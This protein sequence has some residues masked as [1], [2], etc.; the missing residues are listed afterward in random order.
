MADDPL[1]SKFTEDVKNASKDLGKY[2]SELLGVADAVKEAAAAAKTNSGELRDQLNTTTKVRDILD[3]TVALYGRLGSSYISAESLS[4]KILATEAEKSSVLG[5]IDAI[6][7]QIGK[8][9]AFQ[10]LTNEEILAATK[11]INDFNSDGLDINQRALLL[12]MDN[13]DYLDKAI[14]SQNKLNGLLDEGNDQYA[15]T[16]LKGSAIKKV[17]SSIAN[18]PI[19]GPFLQFDLIGEKFQ[20]SIK[21]GYNEIF[22]QS[23]ILFDSPLIKLL[24]SGVIISKLIDISKKYIDLIFEIDK[25]VTKI[26]N[27]LGMSKEAGEALYATFASTSADTIFGSRGLVDGLDKAFYSIRNMS[28]ASAELGESLGTNAMFTDKMVQG[29][30]LMTKQM[31]MTSEEAAGIQSLSLLT[32]KAA[33]KTLQ[34]IIKQNN[35]SLSYRKIIR[36]VANISAELSMRYG[37]DPEQI[38]KAVVQAN[39]LGMSLE[40]T[41]KISNSLLNFEQS[42]EGELESEL[43]L[44]RQ[45]NFEKAR[46]LALMGKSAEASSLLLKQI[47]GITE[48]EKMNVIQRERVAAA[49]GLSVD[50]LSKAAI[51]EQVLTNLGAENEAALTE[52]VRILRENNDLAGMAALQQE[53][54]RVK[55][56][57]ILLQDIAKA[58]M[59]EKYEETMNKLKDILG[60]LLSHST[61]LKLAFMGIALVATGIATSMMYAAMAS[62]IASGGI[63][64]ILGGAAIGAT[65]LSGIGA[66]VAPFAIPA[67]VGDSM[68]EP[69]GETISMPKGTLLPD[70]NDYV[71]TST[72]P[73]P[74]GGNG[75]D[76]AMLSKLDLLIQ[77]TAAG[78]MI[79]YD[80]ITAGTA[81]GMSYNS[82][83]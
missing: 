55:G 15:E 23:K 39:K 83:A 47:G 79:K 51:K 71:Y 43:L 80:T 42:I 3:D 17:L 53:A 64:A 69:G 4:K 18:I 74:T 56:G 27:D 26:S 29:Q 36:E 7:K 31:K 2:K 66:A 65:A 10:G 20:K 63:T 45:F 57:D 30:I 32:G 62:M 60:V 67:M 12:A 61:A 59:A 22:K 38:A 78:K 28:S 49:I 73:L 82:Y 8:T 37:N 81:H 11:S 54:A 75:D 68:T 24:L 9:A 41:R 25:G 33:D 40:E 14:I 13:V 52:R 77:H 50:E 72:N 1:D 34:S 21:D 48:L 5:N 70:K 16:Y 35:A 19:I 76:S 46:E 44:G 6:Y 58:S